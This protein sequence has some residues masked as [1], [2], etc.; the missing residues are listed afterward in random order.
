MKPYIDE[1]IDDTSWVR[2]FDPNV[3]ESEEYVW[4]RDYYDREVIVLEGEGWQF[5]FDNELPKSINIGNKLFISKM[6]YHRLL[7]GDSKLKI[8]IRERRNGNIV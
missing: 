5:Q 4:H 2:T 1:R 8:E 6:I 3:T 7:P